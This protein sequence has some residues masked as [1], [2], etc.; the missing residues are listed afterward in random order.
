[1]LAK[2]QLLNPY[3][4]V[5]IYSFICITLYIPCLA[6]YQCK[7]LHEPISAHLVWCYI[8]LKTQN[9]KIKHENIVAYLASMFFPYI[10]N[11]LILFSYMLSAQTV[12]QDIY[13]EYICCWNRCTAELFKC[14]PSLF[15]SQIYLF[16]SLI[17][18]V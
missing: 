6:P 5:N 15:T 9:V 3:S 13:T 8:N 1:M 18:Y 11:N 4:P 16:N 7:S 17:I 14:Y 2:Q 10:F 12:I